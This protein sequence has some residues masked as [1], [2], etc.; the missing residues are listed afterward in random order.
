[1]KNDPRAMF[2]AA[3]KAQAAA[4]WMHAKQLGQE[5]ISRYS[6]LTVRINRR[7]LRRF[8]LCRILD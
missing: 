5:G 8:P 1:M 7:A 2:T 4:D 6:S 3:S